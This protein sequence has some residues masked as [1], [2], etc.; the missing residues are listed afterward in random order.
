MRYNK[1]IPVATQPNDEKIVFSFELLDSNE[2]F[3]IDCTCSNWST[4]L[5]NMM[6]SISSVTRKRFKTDISFRRG[7]YR[8]HKHDVKPPVPFPV[9]VN[10]EEVEQ[11]RLGASKG[12]IHGFL[13]EN[14]FYVV[15][16]DPLHNMYPD[17][18]HGG[19]R[20]IKPAVTCCG[21]RDEEL[22]TLS[23]EN[24]N[25]KELLGADNA[26]SIPRD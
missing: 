11:I 18:R 12:G 20:K 2:Y 19:L 23:K 26:G 8:I 15:W 24:Q 9:N 13:A 7:T 25:Y 3:N 4:D 6:Q 21:W 1:P 17:D 5:M 22:K 14:V 10:F 16:L